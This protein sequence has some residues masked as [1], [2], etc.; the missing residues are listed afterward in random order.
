MNGPTSEPAADASELIDRR[1]LLWLAGAA[2]L[3]ATLGGC[4]TKAAP[5]PSSA[6]SISVA[7]SPGSGA[8]TSSLLAPPPSAPISESGQM[9]C[10]EAW[11]ARPPRPGGVTHTLTR[12]T[13][14]H[15]GVVLGDNSNAPG[16]LRQH[17]RYHQDS[18]GWIDI[19]Y[20]VSVDRDGNVYELRKPELVGDTATSYDPT[21]HFLVVC[22]GNFDIEDIT[23]AQ[24]HGAALAFAWA[25]QQFGI[26][27]ATLGGHRDASP[28]TECPGASLYAHVASGD[29][30]RRIDDL[31]TAGTVELRK[32]CGPEAEAIVAD[33][34][35]GRG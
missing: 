32:I 18:K 6:P 1:R 8:P 11:G 7:A 14:H 35:A 29:L 24:L 15:T 28:D 22:E 25:A 30:K 2:G 19:A 16:R 31:A 9:L 20:H 17:Q 23:E 26:P 34:E 27:T 10:R 33:I 3:A 4:S 12:M 13:I 21:G 5:G